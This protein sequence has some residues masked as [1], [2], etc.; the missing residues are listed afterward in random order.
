MPT[1]D[2]WILDRLGPD[3]EV[4]AL[5]EALRQQEIPTRIVEFSELRPTIEGLAIPSSNWGTPSLAVVTARVLT[6]HTEGD[7]AFLYD[8]LTMLEDQGVRL[9]NPAGA[10]R[11]CQNKIH[12]AATLRAAGV[13]VPDTV[14]VRQTR[15]A[16]ECLDRWRDVI[17][18]PVFGHASVDVLRILPSGTGGRDGVLLGLREDIV[19]WHLLRRHHVLCA[20]PF[21]ENPGRDLRAIVI[22]DRVA[23][24]HYHISTTPDGSVRSLFHPLKWA[25]APLTAE[26]EQILLAST[27][28]LN[29]DLATIDM[30]EGPNGPVVIEVNP[31]VSRWEPIERTDLDLTPH[32]IT[33]AQVELLKDLAGTPTKSAPAQGE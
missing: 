5:Q 21:I 25:P 26:I 32:G 1:D 30:V 22:G 4:R 27:S 24:C 7:L 10:L 2:V 15:D 12:Q 9:V 3:W 13:P 18:K 33:A 14:A 31:T 28:A 16:E 20:Q 6:R 19:L 23:S 11:R 17:I 29:L 8:W